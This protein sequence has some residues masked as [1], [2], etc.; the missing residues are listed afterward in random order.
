MNPVIS[1]VGS[2]QATRAEAEYAEE[3]G[4]LLAQRGAIVAC[5]G[6]QGVMAAVCRG[7]AMAGGITIG[8]LPGNDPGEGN[9]HLTAAIPT[10][11]GQARNALVAAA[12]QSVIAIGGGPGTLSEVALAL[13]AG[14][15]VI[16]LNT[17]N[18]TRPNGKEIQILRAR[19]AAE[20]VELALGD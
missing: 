2:A 14:R 5:G 17:W 18:A 1:V 20:A 16:G 9:E 7:A 10:G 15:R 19:N 13:K 8:L 3:V 11:L 6:G 12:G 4:R